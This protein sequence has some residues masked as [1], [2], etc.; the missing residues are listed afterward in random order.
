MKNILRLSDIVDKHKVT[1]DTS[2]ERAL[3]V[4]FP[5]KIVKFK[6]LSNRLWGLIP[7]DDSFYEEHPIDSEKG[8]Q[9]VFIP[10]KKT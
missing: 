10:Q 4:H 3:R 2:E 6:E 9:F 7:S 1:L 8:L 5:R